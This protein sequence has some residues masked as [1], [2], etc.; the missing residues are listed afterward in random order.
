[1]PA[2]VAWRGGAAGGRGWG[3][4]GCGLQGDAVLGE[5]GAGEP[6]GVADGVL[7][8]AQEVADGVLAQ[9]EVVVEQGGQDVVGEVQA[10]GG[11]A[12]VAAAGA[13]AALVA[14]GFLLGFP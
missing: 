7:A 13:A 5:E 14:G 9:G 11:V 1:M 4:G 3:G 10:G 12:G 8:D 6:D 2:W